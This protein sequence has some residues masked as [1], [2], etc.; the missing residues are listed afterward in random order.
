M[1]GLFYI[2]AGIIGWIQFIWTPIYFGISEVNAY[3]WA[4]CANCRAFVW[5]PASIAIIMGGL[6]IIMDKFSN[7]DYQVSIH[8]GYLFYLVVTI[9]VDV[10]TIF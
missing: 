8:K 10:L 9:I 2:L 3:V 4:V 1:R 5:I 7:S 6:Y